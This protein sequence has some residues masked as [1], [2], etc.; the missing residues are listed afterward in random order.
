MCMP[1]ACQNY[2]QCVAS[3]KQ[4]VVCHVGFGLKYQGFIMHLHL[5]ITGCVCCNAITLS[6]NSLRAA[7]L[8]TSMFVLSH[9]MCRKHCSQ[10]HCSSHQLNCKYF[11]AL[12]HPLPCH[13]WVP[14]L[15]S[16]WQPH[17]QRRR[18]GTLGYI[19]RLVHLPHTVASKTSQCV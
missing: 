7:P 6:C 19:W 14:G 9:P 16:A 12:R 15:V 5:A 18:T 2:H 3:E 17:S 4:R 10:S 8:P 13:A 1:C 11:Q